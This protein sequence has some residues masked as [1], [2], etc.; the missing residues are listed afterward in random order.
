MKTN[1][2]L[3]MLSATAATVAAM[4]A[5]DGGTRLGRS[6]DRPSTDPPTLNAP[7]APAGIPMAADPA[8]P[9]S[10]VLPEEPLPASEQAQPGRTYDVR[11]LG[12]NAAA[13][14]QARVPVK[15]VRVSA[16]GYSLPV[17]FTPS[18]ADLANTANAWRIAQVFIPDSLQELQV[19]LVFD[20]G[21]TFV[22]GAEQGA[23]AT[24]VA[25]VHFEMSRRE[26]QEHGRVVV[27]VDVERSFLAHDAQ[28]ILLPR[29]TVRF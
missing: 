22:R 15:E 20:E 12:V 18:T 1:L 6:G 28:R 7:D 17:Q 27:H 29:M 19:T 5:C 26:L 13:W 16:G 4:M 8:V 3:V 10:E 2:K 24:R 25:P 23:L 11:L 21:G 9:E 14:S